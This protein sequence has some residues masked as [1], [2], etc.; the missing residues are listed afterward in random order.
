[1]FK[2]GFARFCNAK[3]SSDLSDIDNQFIHLTNVSIQKHGEDYNEKHGNKWSTENLKL[4][5]QGTRGEE[6]TEKLFQRIEFIVIQSLKS[7]QVGVSIVE[8]DI[9]VAVVVVADLSLSPFF[10]ELCVTFAHSFLRSFSLRSHL[11]RDK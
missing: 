2:E 3:Y 5:L 8:V 7:V 10:V 1:M 9:S 6:A 11:S 4:Y